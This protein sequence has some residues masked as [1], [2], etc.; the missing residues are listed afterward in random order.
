[1]TFDNLFLIKWGA[2]ILTYVVFQEVSSS[3]K[4]S[5]TC[6][7]L[8]HQANLSIERRFYESTDKHEG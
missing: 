1:M 2:E 6:K 4:A 3:Q 5:K 7:A 8:R